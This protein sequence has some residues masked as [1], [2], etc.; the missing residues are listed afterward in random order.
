ME[1]GNP[2]ALGALAL[3]VGGGGGG[4]AAFFAGGGGGDLKHILNFLSKIS[5]RLGITQP[6]IERCC[7]VYM[8][9]CRD[10]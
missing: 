5:G 6:L 8:N 4:G 7:F 2:L 3:G 10:P 1:S 9:P